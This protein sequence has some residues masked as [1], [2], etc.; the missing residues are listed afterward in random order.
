MPKKS[1]F[2]FFSQQQSQEL[3][4]TVNE[5]FIR[6]FSHQINQK[7]TIFRR[8]ENGYYGWANK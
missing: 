5:E 2:L 8:V 7:V 4:S 3:Y 1:K 6:F